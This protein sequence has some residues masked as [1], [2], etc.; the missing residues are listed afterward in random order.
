MEQDG[1]LKSLAERLKEKAEQERIETEKVFSEQLNTL[2]SNLQE[3]STNALHTMS[4]A[5][6][7]EI[8]NAAAELN[9]HYKF[10]SLAFARKWIASTVLGIFLCLGMLLG[11]WSWVE[12]LIWKA[13]NARIELAQLRTDYQ[14][15]RET[16]E[17]L[18]AEAWGVTMRESENGRFLILPPGMIPDPA[19]FWNVG[20][21]KAIRLE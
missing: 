14:E 13:E 4:D 17:M 3:S 11:G 15:Q 7:Q 5:M 21:R 18:K 19:Q 10:L 16:L 9:H 20:N 8:T 1:H 12:L 6:A 2:S